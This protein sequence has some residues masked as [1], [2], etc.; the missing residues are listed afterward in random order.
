M[1]RTFP[2]ERAVIYYQP[3]EKLANYEKVIFTITAICARLGI[4][5]I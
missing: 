3:I 4:S 1:K 2:V 5:T